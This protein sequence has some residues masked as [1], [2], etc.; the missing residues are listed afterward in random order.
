[1]KKYIILF[2]TLFICF[3]GNGQTIND[4]KKIFDYD[5]GE[6]LDIKILNT[7]DT[8]QCTIYKIAYSTINGLKVT[9]SLLIPKQKL[10]EFPVVIFLSDALQNKDVF[11]TQALDLASSAFASI[12]ID[13][14]PQ[15]P[16]PYLMN[17]HNFAEPRKDFTAYRQAAIDIRRCIDLLEQHPKID[18][19]RIAFVGNGDGAMAGAIISGIESRI[20]TYILMSC[21]ACYSCNLRT[22]NDPLITKARSALT[23]EQIT[24]YELTLK[25]LNP[26]NYLP[27]HRNMLIFF[28]FAQN[29]PYF[30][31]IIAKET[32][33]ITNEPK[34]QKF[35]NTT[36]QGLIDLPEAKADQ[37]KWLKDHL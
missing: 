9:A 20:L 6:D 29:D 35:Y 2:L 24:Q 10:R 37:K 28:Q 33:R 14:L 11:L 26:S 13:P 3:C 1:M 34:S 21:P 12:L 19:N 18:R 8:V 32:V 16:E 7:K 5:K 36:N 4:L 17:Y 31:E 30:D 22:S 23:S 27:F 15:R 25:P